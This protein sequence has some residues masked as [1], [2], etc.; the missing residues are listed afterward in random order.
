[1]LKSAQTRLRIAKSRNL[2]QRNPDKNPCLSVRINRSLIKSICGLQFQTRVDL[3]TLPK[4][5]SGRNFENWNVK[6]TLKFVSNDKYQ[7]DYPRFEPVKY[8]SSRIILFKD[9]SNI[10]FVKRIL[11]LD[12]SQTKNFQ[13]EFSANRKKKTALRMIH[14]TSVHLNT[15]LSKFY[16][17]I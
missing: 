5:Y 6:M 2:I 15:E 1:M 10:C 11:C 8:H 9:I 12:K 7:N 14:L 4:R 17:S 16:E 3:L 13:S